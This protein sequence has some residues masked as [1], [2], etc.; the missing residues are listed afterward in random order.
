MA[1]F[2]LHLLARGAV[3]SNYFLGIILFEVERLVD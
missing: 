3:I 1:M 2:R